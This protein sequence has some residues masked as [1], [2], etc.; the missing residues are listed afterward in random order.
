MQES[1]HRASKNTAV[2]TIDRLS[3]L[4][5]RVLGSYRPPT[6]VTVRNML[7]TFVVLTGVVWY[8]DGADEALPMLMAGLM[9]LTLNLFV[10]TRGRPD[11]D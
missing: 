9:G 4:D 1:A 5:R 6:L 7:A 10:T 8:R 3:A 11:R 2:R